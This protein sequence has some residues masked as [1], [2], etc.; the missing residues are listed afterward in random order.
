M[1]GPPSARTASMGGVARADGTAE[2]DRAAGSA[3]VLVHC[4]TPS[5]ATRRPRDPLLPA[6]RHAGDQAR[7]PLRRRGRL[8]RVPALR[9]TATRSTGTRAERE[10]D[11]GPRALP[12]AGRHATT[13]ASSRSAAARTAPTRRIRMLE[14]GMNPL[15]VTATTDKLSDIGRRNIENLKALGVDYVEVHDEP[16]RAAARSTGSALDAGRRHLVARAR[17]DLHD[18]GARSP[19]SSASRSSSG[20]RTR[21][22]STAGRRRR[23]SD[24]VLTRRW[25]EEFGG[26]LGLR[27]SRPRRPGRHRAAAPDPVHV[28]DRRGARASRRD[29]HLPRLLPAVGRLRER[30][31]RPGARLRDVPARRSRARSSTTRTSTTTRPASTTTS[32]S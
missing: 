32:S 10:L 17:H 18:P 21:R 26:L 3:G 30:A 20:A 4:A 13:T 31:R 9:A 23:P 7:H 25:L 14:L 11:A 16:G 1:A 5:S 15:C 28:P 29:R 8:Q 27:V 22:T 12:L 19:C 24:N 6:L 2:P